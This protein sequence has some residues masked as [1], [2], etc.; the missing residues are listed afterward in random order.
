MERLNATYRIKNE[1]G[2]Y[3]EVMLKTTAEQVF[4]EDGKNLQEKLNNGDLGVSGG[5]EGRKIDW[6]SDII[7]NPMIK[8]GAGQNSFTCGENAMAT[9]VASSSI[10]NDTTA[11]GNYSYAGGCN[12]K[13]I[14][15]GSH[16]EGIGCVTGANHHSST[17]NVAAH[18]EGY[19][20]TASG[21][22]SHCEGHYGIA[23]GDG[24]HVEGYRL[25]NGKQIAQGKGSHVEGIDCMAGANYHSSESN[26][27]AHAE[28]CGAV[29]EGSYSH[30]EGYYT[31]A[32]GNASHASG[33]HT[34]AQG[35]AQTVIG[36][37]NNTSENDLFIIGNGSGEYNRSNALRVT[38]EGST[39]AKGVYNSTGA[40]YA[41]LFEWSD[42][43][44]DK[45]D[46][47]G[48]FVTFEKGTQ[49]IRKANASD[50][51]ILG[52]VS[53]NAAILGDNFDEEWKDKY[54]RDKWGRIVYQ[55]VIIPM[56][57]ITVNHADGS[58]EEIIVES[59]RIEKQPII[60]PNYQSNKNYIPREERPEWSP[61]GLLGKLLVY[62]DGTCE[63]GGYCKPNNDG[64]AT[65]SEDGYYVMER[66]NENIIKIMFK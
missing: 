44:L 16:S 37:C 31:K 11:S 18:A 20:T 55:N 19:Y 25:T 36:T 42:L 61:I 6:N 59:E 46:R 8:R 52:V 58:K 53:V 57:T 29:A 54:I 35:Y 27:A 3:N 49:K 14:G 10:G 62:D 34:I 51:Y 33:N 22:Y 56:K 13:A 45:E 39:Y 26:I 66:T 5:Q 48:F 64:I 9:G 50:K 65:N 7:N 12:T 4:F 23:L 43:N 60:N 15:A 40:D 47:I 24:S 17:T 38:K 63:V 32:I 30:A 1:R 2:E 28:G 41:E 21:K